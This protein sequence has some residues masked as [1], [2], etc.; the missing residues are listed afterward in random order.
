MMQGD[1]GIYFQKIGNFWKTREIAE[2]IGKVWK[3]E[4]EKY[5]QVFTWF[6]NL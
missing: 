4:L 3:H 5:K 6:T 2:L 1:E